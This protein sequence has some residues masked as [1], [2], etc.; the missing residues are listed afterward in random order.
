MARVRSTARVTRDGEETEATETAPISEVM[1]QSG[2]VVTEGA[3]DEGTF[4]AEAEYADIEEDVVGEEE[5]D[6]NT[7]MR[8]KLSH[9]DFKKSNVSE[10]DMPMMIKL[11]Y[12]G[13]AKKKLIRFC[14]EEPTPTPKNDE[15]VVFRS[16]F[17]AGLR[18]PLNEMIGEVLENYEIYLHQLTPNAI[19]R[20]DV[21]IW[22]LQSQGIDPNVEAFC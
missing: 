1:K 21:F 16:F 11:G 2:L 6:Y 20:L 14:G 18:F 22:T 10:A 17:R 8:A 7:L 3:A 5:E 13:E 19:V 12:F 9:L 4:V 15:V